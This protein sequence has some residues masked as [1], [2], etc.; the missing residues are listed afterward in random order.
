MVLTNG[1]WRYH[2]IFVNDNQINITVCRKQVL[3]WQLD[4]SVSR[5]IGLPKGPC[6]YP[7]ALYF[8]Q[9]NFKVSIVMAYE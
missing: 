7:A 5:L 4:I 6:R 2:P 8:R 9:L 1:V 3:A